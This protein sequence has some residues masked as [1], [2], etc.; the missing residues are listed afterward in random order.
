MD[1]TAFAL[2]RENQM[3]IV[4]FDMNVRGNIQRVVGGD[5]VGTRVVTDS[6]P[7]RFAG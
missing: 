2:C 4:V 6:E 7:T 3:G 1:A 5:P